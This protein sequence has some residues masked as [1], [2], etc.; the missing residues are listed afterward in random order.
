MW[1]LQCAHWEFTGL[2]HKSWWHTPKLCIDHTQNQHG[3]SSIEFLS[4]CKF[5]VLNGRFGV[6]S[7]DFTFQSTTGH[8]VVVYIS[9]PHDIYN[10]CPNFRVIPCNSI[11]ENA[12]IVGLQVENSRIPDHGFLMFDYNLRQ[13]VEHFTTTSIPD[14]NKY[15]S[16]NSSQ[17]GKKY[18]LQCIRSAFMTPTAVRNHLLNV[19]RENIDKTYITNYV[20]SSQRKWSRTSLYSIGQKDLVKIFTNHIKRSAWNTKNRTILYWN[21]R[22][23]MNIRNFCENSTSEW[24]SSSSQTILEQ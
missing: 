20:E 3:N 19:V 18:K 11:V 14:S 17:C 13:R 4:D 10:Q 7:N 21:K 16:T 1:R 15:E 2:W 22:H 5:C 6:D 23:I 12:E 9:V 8:S 24:V